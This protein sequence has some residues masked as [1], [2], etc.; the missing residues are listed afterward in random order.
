MKTHIER[1][2]IVGDKALFHVFYNDTK[3]RSFAS[4]KAALA[5]KKELEAN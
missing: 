3:M 5:F 4:H 1:E 2:D